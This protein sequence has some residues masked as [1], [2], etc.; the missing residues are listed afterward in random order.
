MTLEVTPAIFYELVNK[1]E[2][3]SLKIWLFSLKKNKINKKYF[4]F[5]ELFIKSPKIVISIN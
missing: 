4:K 5:T 1:I 3:F 2:M